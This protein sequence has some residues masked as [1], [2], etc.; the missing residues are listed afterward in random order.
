MTVR[1]TAANLGRETPTTK[2]Q[3][4]CEDSGP[5]G[6]IAALGNHL[7]AEKNAYYCKKYK[8]IY[9]KIRLCLIDAINHL[10]RLQNPVFSFLLPNY[11]DTLASIKRFIYQFYLKDMR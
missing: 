4:E 8:F 5:T 11:I 7:K 2:T 6:L 9:R 3:S 1:K 10:L